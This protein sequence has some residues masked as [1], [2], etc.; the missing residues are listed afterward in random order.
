MGNSHLTRISLDRLYTLDSQDAEVMENDNS[1]QRER[2]KKYINAVMETLLSDNQRMIIKMHY[3]GLPTS[4]IA[5]ICCISQR[6]VQK[7]IK[8]AMKILI[9]QKNIFQKAN[10]IGS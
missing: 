9:Q 6:A 8:A 4:E 7:N 3:G 1:E 2:M 5:I 10:E